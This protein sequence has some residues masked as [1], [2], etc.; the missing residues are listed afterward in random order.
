M[1]ARTL[2][3]ARWSCR[4]CADCCKGFA[5]GPV[6][7]AIIEGLR[8]R[9]IA[10][11]WAPAREAPWVEEREEG[12]FLTHR[13]GHCVF[14]QQDGACAVHRLYGAAA[15]PDFCRAYPFIVVE[16]EGGAPAVVVR[17]DCGGLHESYVDGALV[18]A[19]VAEL[20]E[21]E[22]P[23]LPPLI[24][25]VE[26]LPGMA[27]DASTWASLRPRLLERLKARALTPEAAVG[28]LRQAVLT[29]AGRRLPEADPAE[30]RAAIASVLGALESTLGRAVEAA[31]PGADGQRDRLAEV[32]ADLA[33]A[34]QAPPPL[35]AEGIDYLGLVLRSDL[36]GRRAFALG[37][38]PAG[39]GRYLLDVTI[40][41][42]A[43]GSPAELGPPLS[44]WLRVAAHPALQA[45]LRQAR[46]ALV[47]AFVHAG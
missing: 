17:A 40:A 29:A 32:Q 8:A 37:G 18:E 47:A 4:G 44:R 10:A 12:A 5:F 26:V 41:R 16:E 38:L 43:G 14:L 45:L 28:D 27:V 39:L 11:D 42:A 3:D 22:V 30:G 46:P 9:G 24:G 6:Q 25:D 23:H 36:L 2:P 31:P 35:T 20:L 21:L 13:D 33:R 7:P 1:K 34:L 19:Q 15:K